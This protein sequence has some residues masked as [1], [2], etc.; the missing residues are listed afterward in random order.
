[1]DSTR[2]LRTMPG[3]FGSND[4]LPNG[5]WTAPTAM[6]ALSQPRGGVK[7]YS[8]VEMPARPMM[9]ARPELPSVSQLGAMP[10]RY[11]QH[12]E[13]LGEHEERSR[14]QMDQVRRHEDALRQLTEKLLRS[15]D[16]HDETLSQRADGGFRRHDEHDEA[17][18]RRHDAL[19]REQDELFRTD[20]ALSRH[21]KELFRPHDETPDYNAPYTPV[22]QMR[23][24]PGSFEGA[25]DHS[26]HF[27]SLARLPPQPLQDF[28]NAP[29]RGNLHI[30][31]PSSHY[32]RVVTGQIGNTPEVTVRRAPS[33]RISQN[34]S[35]ASATLRRNPSRKENLEMS[36]NLAGKWPT[37][38]I[39]PYMAYEV[40]RANPTP[41]RT[42]KPRTP[43]LGTPA[44]TSTPR[45][46]TQATA[47]TIRATSKPSTPNPATIKPSES[48]PVTPQAAAV[49]LSRDQ[50]Y[51]AHEDKLGVMSA[52]K[53][54]WS[55]TGQMCDVNYTSLS[56]SIQSQL[57]NS[58]P[59]GAG[60]QGSVH[61]V[62]CHGVP[63]ARKS[64]HIDPPSLLAA[65]KTE[66][67]HLRSLAGHPHMVQL[68]GTYITPH[69]A[70]EM[71]HILTF[72]VADCDMHTF[73]DDYE[74]VLSGTADA[75][76]ISRG[77]TAA[78]LK[79]TASRYTPIS[80]Q[81]RTILKQ[82]LGCITAAIQY[83]HISKVAHDD[84]KPANVLLRG[85]QVYITDFGLSRDRRGAT[86]TSTE[87]YPG[88]T[89][90]WTA[91][92][93][94]DQEAHNPFKA[95]VYS[96]GCIFMHVVS[97]LS[98]KKKK[99]K[100]CAEILQSPASRR[101]AYIEEHFASIYQGPW[102]DE[103][104]PESYQ[105]LIAMTV[106]ML[107]NDRTLRP[108]VSDVNDRLLTIGGA[109]KVFHSTCCHQHL[110]QP[111]LKVAETSVGNGA[112]KTT[113]TP[114]ARH[115]TP[116]P[117]PQN[118]LSTVPLGSPIK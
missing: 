74:Q 30:L 113:S 110:N 6:P 12:E 73:L 101:E 87:R 29:Y 112:A 35:L 58:T 63:L 19:T 8:P 26:N 44:E 53:T 81:L 77:S 102:Y 60:G 106:E 67:K 104:P 9:P 2:G 24:M 40:V 36:A 114:T 57:Q 51:K 3:A 79:G 99:M 22:P 95:D 28:N 38:D 43:N 107:Q 111:P 68:V 61:R 54:Y 10:K 70:Y 31:D 23:T 17:F 11:P 118:I 80:A 98:A 108:T 33:T 25:D 41:P 93:K 1:M 59:L 37:V 117:A 96:V 82:T 97:L 72:P 32:S 34:V 5:N 21:D 103:T 7:R 56:P 42:P 90:G 4:D 46:G 47:T 13:P 75:A 20:G 92:E 105:K 49:P 14:E 27:T 66:V 88:H 91:P 89:R 39:D 83:M 115:P 71:L 86:N 84:I 78:G 45:S 85:G 62:V 109:R 100:D 69:H 16:Q 52:R 50:E 48:K 65:I 15:Q 76:V 64:I 94:E 116:I 18:Q 55:Q